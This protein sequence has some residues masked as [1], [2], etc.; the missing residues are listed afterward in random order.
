M[1]NKYTVCTR[2]YTFNQEAYILDALNGFVMQETTFPVVSCIVDDASTDN[3]PQ[4]LRDYFNTHFDVDDSSCAFRENTD[5][6]EVLFARH[7]T[8]KNCYF[9][10]VLLK[11]NHFKKK[12]KRPYLTRW[13]DNSKYIALC[14]G[15]DYWTDPKKL[16]VQVEYMESHPQ[17]TLTVHPAYWKKQDELLLR[18]CQEPSPKDYSV[19]ELIRYGG[20]YF[21]TASFVYRPELDGERPDWRRKAGVGDFPLQIL[22]GIYGTVHYI[23]EIMC[24]YRWQSSGAWSQNMRNAQYAIAFQKNK[25]EW[26]TL[27]DKETG[28]Q[29][30]KAIYDHMFMHFQELYKLREIGVWE[31]AK[32]V[33]RSGEKQYGQLIKDFLKVELTPLYRILIRLFK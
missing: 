12:S 15:D 32:A 4:V 8:N 20:L 22:A 19:E 29:Y 25:I 21:A 31:Y 9:A 11:E 13:I 10:V 5:Y 14:E 16:Q 28:H 7:K 17:C 30:R 27:L 33:H 6:G 23:P 1:T 26:M 3:E 2:C 18:G 24:V